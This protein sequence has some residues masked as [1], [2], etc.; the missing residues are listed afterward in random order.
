MRSALATLLLSVGLL[1]FQ[2]PA[3]ITPGA[4]GAPSNGGGA[5]D[6]G[7]PRKVAPIERVCVLGASLSDGF[8][9]KNDVGVNVTL[10]TVVE[11]S[12]L[13]GHDPIFHKASKMLFVN[14]VQVG[15]ETAAA[16]KGRNP[17]LVVGVDFLFWFGYGAVKAESDRMALLEKGLAILSEFKCPVLVGDFPDVSD[18]VAGSTP[19]TADFMLA[20]EQVPQPETLKKLNERLQAWVVEHPNVVVVPLANLVAHVRADEEI[21][22]H[23]N[24][25]F[26]GSLKGLLQKDRLHPT[27]EGTIALWLAGLDALVAKNPEVPASAFDWDWKSIWRKI[28]AA[29]EKER[30]AEL[31]KGRKKVPKPPPPPP[32]PTPEKQRRMKE[33]LDGGRDASGG[34]DH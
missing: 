3:P 34:H 13:D 22:I 29:T 26:K 2:S 4:P 19:E 20:K 24:R 18:A 21:T 11:A 10:A 15:T 28:F 23:G 9:L 16:A 12:L 25:W 8:G 1:S 31:E 30:R 17:T 5:G 27:L 6:A 7:M 14:P 32:E 33:G